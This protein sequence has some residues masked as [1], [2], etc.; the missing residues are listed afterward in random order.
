MSDKITPLLSKESVEKIKSVME[1]LESKKL[2]IA[3]RIEAERAEKYI[4]FIDDSLGVFAWLLT[5]T[6]VKL[7]IFKPK[8][9]RQN[10]HPN[11]PA[12]ARKTIPLYSKES[13][14]KI[15]S[16]MEQLESKKQEVAENFD[17]GHAEKCIA[18]INGRLETFQLLL[19]CNPVRIKKTAE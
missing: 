2:E 5:G 6:S 11:E 9:L 19:D 10:I 8:E 1:Q 16:V 12:T 15:K 7:E 4:R 14:E 13:V 18:G 3:E 17:P